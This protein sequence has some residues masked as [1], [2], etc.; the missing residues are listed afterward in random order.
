VET[1]DSVFCYWA[2]DPFPL[3]L[4]S[5]SVYG[6]QCRCKR[7]PE[8]RFAVQLPYAIRRTQWHAVFSAQFLNMSIA[9]A[10]N[11]VL[12]PAVNRPPTQVD[13]D[14]RRRV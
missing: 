5:R 9:M 6:R 13:P 12:E 1:V 8:E 2:P 7:S 10:C 11:P 4:L 14:N 3:M